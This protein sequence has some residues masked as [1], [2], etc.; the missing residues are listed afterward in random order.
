[1][2]VP[3]VQGVIDRR[4]LVNFQVDPENLGRVL[5]PSMRPKLVGGMGIGGICLIRLRHIRPTFLP[6]GLGL[7][8]E[9]AAHRIAVEWTRDGRTEEG[10]YIPR[11]DTSSRLSTLF[12]GR[13]FPGEHHLARFEVEETETHL[14]VAVRTL[15][16]ERLVEVR[17]EVAPSL[18]AESV[19]PSLAEASSFFERGFVGYSATRHPG[20]L[21]GLE[22][23]TCSWSVTPLRVESVYSRFFEDE[24]AFPPGTVRFDDALL[25]RNIEHEWHAREP[26]YCGV[27]A[28]GHAARA[29]DSRAPWT[30]SISRRS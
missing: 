20:A 15:D 6:A 21:D 19:F 13:L 23:R 25:M 14:H 10:V 16:G 27:E 3:V 18:P 7:G 4:I 2:K 17:A 9:N 5:P 12:G 1:M 26:L 8:S 22:L 29:V 11:R 30:G 24:S 28:T